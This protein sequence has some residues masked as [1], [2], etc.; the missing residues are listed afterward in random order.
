MDTEVGV[1]MVIGICMI[2]VASVKFGFVEQTAGLDVQ[3]KVLGRSEELA[4]LEFKMSA[5]CIV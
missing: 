5:Q 2:T 4:V 3:R 1:N